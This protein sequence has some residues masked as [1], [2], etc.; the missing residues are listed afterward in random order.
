MRQVVYD[1]KKICYNYVSSYQIILKF[2]LG[3]QNEVL[4]F[5]CNFCFAG[6]FRYM[7]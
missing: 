7:I 6:V 3:R 4:F 1:Q 5:N 2:R